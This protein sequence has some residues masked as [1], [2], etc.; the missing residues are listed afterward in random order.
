[1]HGNQNISTLSAF[2]LGHSV[3][4]EKFPTAEFWM[5]AAET[6]AVFYNFKKPRNWFQGIDS[7]SL[8]SLAVRYDNPIPTRFLTPID[9]SKIPEHEFLNVWGAPESISRFPG[10]LNVYKFGLCT[11]RWGLSM[12]GLETWRKSSKFLMMTFTCRSP[13]YLLYTSGFWPRVRARALRAPVFLGS[14]TRQKGAARPPRPSQLRCFS[15]FKNK[16]NLFSKKMLPFRLQAQTRAARDI[17]FSTGLSCTLLSYV[18]L[19]FMHPLS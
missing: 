3:L 14:L 11:A 4:G 18:E 15:F 1:M 8:C 17:Y 16:N 13:S 19:R 5:I 2:G 10:S 6:E 7:Y 9:C 12:F